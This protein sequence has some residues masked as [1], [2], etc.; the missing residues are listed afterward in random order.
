MNSFDS[1]YRIKAMRDIVYALFNGQQASIEFP[2]F[3]LMFWVYLSHIIIILPLRWGHMEAS[4][5]HI[6]NTIKVIIGSVH[7]SLHLSVFNLRVTR[8]KKWRRKRRRHDTMHINTIH[9]VHIE[10]LLLIRRDL[11]RLFSLMFILRGKIKLNYLVLF[12]IG[13]TKYCN[14]SKI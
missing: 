6:K 13:L 5:T 8:E 2:F 11:S 9:Y 14:I 4:R 7:I 3:S 12:L 10:S 1:I